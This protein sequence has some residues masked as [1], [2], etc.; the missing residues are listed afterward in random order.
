[1]HDRGGVN[2][3]QARSRPSDAAERSQTAGRVARVQNRENERLDDGH[4]VKYLRGYGKLADVVVGHR[5]HLQ[6]THSRDQLRSRFASTPPEW[7]LVPRVC[8]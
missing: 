3:Q 4:E 7:F 1:M 8:A 2:R 6:A 5:Y